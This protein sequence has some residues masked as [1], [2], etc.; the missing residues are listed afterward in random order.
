MVTSLRAPAG[1]R[2]GA[3]WPRKTRTVGNARDS[4]PRSWGRPAVAECTPAELRSR[5]RVRSAGDRLLDV[6]PCS[7]PL[8][9]APQRLG[10]CRVERAAK[11]CQQV[12]A[13]LGGEPGQYLVLHLGDQPPRTLQEPAAL[14]RDRNLPGPAV[15]G[16][17]PAR[18]QAGALELVD[19]RDHRA[20]ID[21]ERRA[22]LLLDGSLA[23]ADDVQQREE[24]R[25][26][27]DG[28]EQLR[29]ARVRCAPEP[30]EQL[31]GELGHRGIGRRMRRH[32][33]SVAQCRQSC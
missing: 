3:A 19:Q 23:S 11:Q 27:P 28:A 31:P 10:G 5:Q 17:R 8:L 15:G 18:G 20:A 2:P 29:G 32:V 9:R 12:A 14:G 6:T 30:E 22:E 1:A 21:A 13:L 4:P 16:R 25:R 7:S 33:G 26:Q 24:G